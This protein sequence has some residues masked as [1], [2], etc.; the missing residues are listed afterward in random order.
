MMGKT[1]G[2]A[3]Y[4][5]THL[6]GIS[7]KGILREDFGVPEFLTIFAVFPKSTLTIAMK[8]FVIDHE[9]RK[10]HGAKSSDTNLEYMKKLHLFIPKHL[11][12]T[13]LVFQTYGLLLE[14]PF[15]NTNLIYQAMKNVWFFVE[16]NES[17]FERNPNQPHLIL[18]VLYGMDVQLRLLLKLISEDGSKPMLWVPF[19]ALLISSKQ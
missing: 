15:G 13:S 14:I 19:K 16:N 12:D 17:A 1:K 10:I 5:P 7:T 6:E 9:N 4:S 3:Q 18:M 2:S 8:N 11:L